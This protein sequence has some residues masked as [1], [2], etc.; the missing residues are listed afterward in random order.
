MLKS[1]WGIKKIQIKVTVEN[2]ENRLVDYVIQEWLFST[3]KVVSSKEE[4]WD[5]KAYC[6]PYYKLVPPKTNVEIK[7]YYF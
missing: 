5:R 3:N 2:R 4:A 1:R 7:K 6:I